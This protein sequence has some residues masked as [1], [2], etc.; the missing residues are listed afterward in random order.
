MDCFFL[1]AHIRPHVQAYNLAFV[2][3]CL[4]N[5]N[6]VFGQGF[7]PI[8]S[9]ATYYVVGVKLDGTGRSMSAVRPGSHHVGVNDFEIGGPMMGP[10]ECRAPTSI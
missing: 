8:E 2:G 6:Q 4:F 5:M 3:A 9:A 10:Q 7:P 1:M